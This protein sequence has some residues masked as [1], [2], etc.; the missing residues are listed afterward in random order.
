MSIPATLSYVEEIVP[1]EKLKVGDEFKSL[2]PP[3]NMREE[4]AS[5]IRKNG[6][7]IPLDV[8]SDYIVLDGHTRAEI[9]KELEYDKVKVRKWNFSSKE[10]RAIAYTLIM[11]LNLE[12]RHLPK[13][14]VLRL[15]REIS[16]KIE[17]VSKERQASEHLAQESGMMPAA[18]EQKMKRIKDEIGVKDVTDDDIKRYSIISTIPFLRQL[19]DEGKISL[20]TAYELYTKAKDKLQKINDLPK[21]EREQLLTTK[22]GRKILLERDDLLQQILDHKLAA[23][24]AINQIKIE[25]KQERAKKKPKAKEALEDEEEESIGGND[26][27]ESEEIDL[28]SEWQKALEEE[29]AKTEQLAT[30]PSEQIEKREGLEDKTQTKFRQIFDELQTK[31]FAELPFEVD[32]VKIG[33]KCYMIN[34]DALLDLEQGNNKWSELSSFLSKNGVILPGDAEGTYVI[35]WKLL[36]R[37]VAWKSH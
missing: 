12:R 14:E 10:N 19:V 26:T 4:L 8:D 27:G 23:S 5:S 20:R 35:P 25:K 18:L 28:L 13:N 15:L 37:C 33:D 3:N 30:K 2:V 34:H 17:N 11:M 6:Q 24:Q 16:E 29:K 7:L 1:I 32:L 9:L 36:G 31:G 22:E 21:Y